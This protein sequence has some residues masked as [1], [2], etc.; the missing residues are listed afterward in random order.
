MYAN[1][2]VSN[3]RDEMTRFLIGINGDFEEECR[4]FILYDNIDLSSLMVYN[5]QVEDSLKKK[6]VRDSR[7]PKPHHQEGP[8]NRGNKNKFCVREY[9]RFIK[10]Q[11]SLGKSN[12]QRSTSPRGGGS[13]P[14]K[15]N[16]GD[17]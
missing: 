8:S 2:L 16:G 1:S 4:F 17:V 12:F 11:Q 7:N 10:R 5:Q 14:K 6:G 3:L 13:E 9:P 15:G